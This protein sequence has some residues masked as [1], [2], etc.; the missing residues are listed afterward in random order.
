MESE[1]GFQELVRRVGPAKAKAQR[2]G[3]G[4]NIWT[5]P[6]AEQIEALSTHACGAFEDFTY[7]LF[8]EPGGLLKVRNKQLY[9]LLCKVRNRLRSRLEDV[10]V[11]AYAYEGDQKADQPPEKLLFSGCYFAAT[12]DREDQQAFVKSVFDKLL[13]EESELDWTD[14]ALAEDARYQ[15]WASVAMVVASLA[16]AAIAVILGL[17]FFT[18]YLKPPEGY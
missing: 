13:Q 5:P 17:Y 15:R 7:A 6:L 12:G 8:R 14:A 9:A 11:N 18:D 10:L 16:G 2:F 3:K 1:A 4:F